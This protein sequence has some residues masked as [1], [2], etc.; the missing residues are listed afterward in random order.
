MWE[1]FSIDNEVNDEEVFH[2]PIPNVNESGTVIESKNCIYG[3][4]KTNR[5]SLCPVCSIKV[6]PCLINET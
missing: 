2:V 1:D 3:C 4:K 5:V 6:M